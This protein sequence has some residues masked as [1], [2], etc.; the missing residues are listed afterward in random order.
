MRGGITL[1]AATPVINRLLWL[2]SNI[3]KNIYTHTCIWGLQVE[4]C[5]LLGCDFFQSI[6]TRLRG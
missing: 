4:G 1:A 5:G 6:F 2:L 3:T